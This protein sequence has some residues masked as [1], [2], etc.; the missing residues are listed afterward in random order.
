MGQDPSESTLPGHVDS[1]EVLKI[2]D[3][4]KWYPLR[5]GF[6][7]TLL[8]RD[9]L[10]VKAVD[11]I[12][13]TVRKGEVLALAG[14]SGSGKTTTGKVLLRL[15]KPTS[16]S[17]FFQ[18]K[19]ITKLSEKELK[20]LRREMQIVFQDPFESLNP[21]MTIKEIVAEPIRVQHASA[22]EAELEEMVKKAL[23]DV[24]VV[25]PEEFLYRFPH[26]L[27]GGQRQRVAVAR[28]FVL[29]PS[30]I[31]ADEPVS[32]LDVSIRAEI[33]N[34]MVDLVK[35]SSASIIYITHDIALAKHISDRIGVMY[36]G[37]MMEMGGSQTIVDLPLHPYTQA[38]IA[39]VPV[40]DP[41]SKRTQNVISGEIPSP[42]FPPSGCR[43]HTR[44]PYAHT[45]CTKEEPAL[46]EVE[47]DHYVACHLYT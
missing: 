7:E 12:S 20:P 32:M 47:K 16:G 15:V 31:V 45:R 8:S 41:E 24:E 30:F 10:N 21:R 3:L 19:D 9:E 40:P 27:S 43:F 18:G 37:K 2:E 11:G 36:L 6:F 39:A 23:S 13:F 22:N 46:V 42:V 26:E 28:A 29:G 1:E 33:L 34:L 5:R 35:K 4:R 14:E 25:P 38:L 44:C 17:I